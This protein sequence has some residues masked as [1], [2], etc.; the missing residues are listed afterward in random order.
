MKPPEVAHAIVVQL[1][2]LERDEGDFLGS[3]RAGA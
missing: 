2:G 3:A 1:A